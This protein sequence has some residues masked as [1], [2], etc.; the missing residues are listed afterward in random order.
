ME[1]REHV[2]EKYIDEV[3]EALNGLFP[4]K[5]ELIHYVNSLD[6][7]E[8]AELFIKISRFYL[9]SKKYQPTSY[10][11]LIMIISAI[12]RTIN[13]DKKYQEFYF[14]IESQVS[15]I[16]EEIEKA[17]RIDEKSYL[18]ILKTLRE[19]Y[20]RMYGSQRN[21]LDFF[22]NHVSLSNKIKLIKSFR[23]NLTEVISQFC[24]KSHGR[25]SPFPKTIYEAAKKT[26]QNVEK[27]LMPYCYDWQR[28]F[29]SYGDC[30]LGVSCALDDNQSLID[31]T[32]R[33]VVGDI[34]QMRN[35]FVHTA[36]ITPLNEEDAVGTLAVLGADRRPISIE[37][38][39]QEL[40]TIFESGVKHYFD[41][42][43]K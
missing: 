36:R 32:V 7:S 28:C 29:V 41:V 39:A 26:G 22:Q 30:S 34:Y 19:D 23:A 1:R 13:K 31:R 2:L 10:V 38:T 21:V 42:F 11:K 35:D 14:W 3:Y 16:K 27:G 8:T 9:I 33:K 17:G 25:L 20:F 6:T 43:V 18:S 5:N 37:L 40:Q 15:R 24:L 12:E 4:S